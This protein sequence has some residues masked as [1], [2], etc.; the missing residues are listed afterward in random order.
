MTA[1]GGPKGGAGVQQEKGGVRVSHAHGHVHSTWA[2]PAAFRASGTH[3][4]L[5]DTVEV[6]LQHLFDGR[7]DVLL[8]GSAGQ[9]CKSKPTPGCA[10]VSL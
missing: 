9:H 1:E 8:H 6:T 5:H 4:E 7:D 10:S 2:L 3:L